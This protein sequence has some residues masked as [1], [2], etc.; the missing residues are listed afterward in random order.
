MRIRRLR[1]PPPEPTASRCPVL[2]VVAALFGV[3]VLAAA[4]LAVEARTGRL[5]GPTRAWTAARA[6]LFAASAVAGL[7]LVVPL[8]AGAW[9]LALALLPITALSVLRFSMLLGAWWHGP[10]RTVVVVTVLAVGVLAVLPS[11]PR[12]L[13]RSFVLDELRPGDAVRSPSDSIDPN[14]LRPV[15]S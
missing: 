14:A 9:V 5:A 2:V 13:E 6:S 8:S 7:A 1:L 4:V 12:T 10:V 15:R 11:L 3:L